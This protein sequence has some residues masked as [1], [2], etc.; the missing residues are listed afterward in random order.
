[1]SGDPTVFGHGSSV[2]MS[3]LC[4]IHLLMVDQTHNE[5]TQPSR[6]WE[7]VHISSCGLISFK[8]LLM[9]MHDGP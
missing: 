5:R 8:L 7:K 6:P 2:L 4:S 3:L 9:V 1:M